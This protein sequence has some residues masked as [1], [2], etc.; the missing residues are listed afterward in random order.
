MRISHFFIDRPI[1][2]SV[3]AIVIVILG[4]IALFRLPVAQYPE[5]APPTINVAG[6]YPGASAEIVAET[7]VAP[8]EQQI[9][10]VEGMVYISSNSTADGRFSIAV[11]LRHRHQ[12]RHCPGAGAEPRRRG[13]AAPARAGAADRRHRQQG[14]AR[15]PD[16]GEPLFARP[17]ARRALHLQLRQHPDQGCA[18]AR[19][20]RRFDHG[21]RGA[22]LRHASVARSRPHAGAQP[23]GRRR[24]RRP[25]GAERPGRVRRSQ[26]AAGRAP[27]RLPGRGAH[28]GTSHRSRRLRQHRR[29][30]DRQRRRAHQGRRPRRPSGAG[31]F[32]QFLHRQRPVDRHGRVPTPGLERAQDRQQHRRDDGGAVEEFP[33]R[34]Q[35]PGPLQ[36]DQIHR[37]IRQRRR[38][39]HGGGGDPGGA[40]RGPVPA[41]LGALP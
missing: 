32:G 24:H 30:A 8:I 22:R 3:V 13:D 41:D 19:R 17:F 4:S 34:S 23:D 36:P 38:R 33:E 35:V 25:A 10:G 16:G 28:A 37:R 39:D 11:T 29:Q 15:H 9:N 18:L 1:F 5:I 6:Q 12:S 14:V 27:A 31:L 20:R 7:V 2:A 26:P 40:G 21:V